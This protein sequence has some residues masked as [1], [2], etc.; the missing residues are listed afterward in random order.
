VDLQ[1]TGRPG[2]RWRGFHAV[3]ERRQ[4]APE[5]GPLGAAA[6]VGEAGGARGRDGRRRGAAAARGLVVVIDEG[7]RPLDALL[8][9]VR[10]RRC[11]ERRER[12]RRWPRAPL[13]SSG[14]RKEVTVVS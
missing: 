10:H 11:G 1:R 4:L 5:R 13:S 12:E 9:A 14:T 3:A 8:P 2:G 7:G 6:V